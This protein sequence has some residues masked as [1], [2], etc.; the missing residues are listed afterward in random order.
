M[1]SHL[2]YYTANNQSIS[3]NPHMARKINRTD[4]SKQEH[5]TSFPEEKFWIG[6]CFHPGLLASR[7]NLRCCVAPPRRHLSCNQCSWVAKDINRSQ[8]KWASSF[9]GWRG[10]QAWLNAVVVLQKQCFCP[11]LN[12]PSELHRFRSIRLASCSPPVA[13]KVCLHL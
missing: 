4:I 7:E 3:Q 10:F 5:L 11:S 2:R 9:N 1:S 8:K 6:C 12:S 13:D